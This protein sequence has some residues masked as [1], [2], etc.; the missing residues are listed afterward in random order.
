MTKIF[1]NCFMSILDHALRLW[2]IQTDTL[3]AI[4]GGVEGHRDEVLSAVSWMLQG[5]DFQVHIVVNNPHGAL[6]RKHM[7]FF[8]HTAW[9]AAI[10]FTCDM[11][12]LSYMW[13]NKANKV[14]CVLLVLF[15]IS[16]WILMKE[17]YELVLFL[18]WSKITKLTFILLFLIY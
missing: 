4:F 11:Q 5:K 7:G 17:Y 15:Y 3:V 16:A 6:I 8:F 2:N 10:S 1:P 13:R 9:Q 12:G 18:Y 14:L